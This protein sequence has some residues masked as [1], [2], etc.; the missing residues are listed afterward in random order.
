MK[1]LTTMLCAILLFGG[2][3][4]QNEAKAAITDH[5]NWGQINA[6]QSSIVG[7]ITGLQQ[8]YYVIHGHY[9]QGLQTPVKAVNELDGTEEVQIAYGLKPSD[10]EESWNDFSPNDF[11]QGTKFRI[12]VT[13]DVYSAPEGDGYIVT[14]E[15]NYPAIGPDSYGTE[16]N[17]WIYQHNEGPVSYG[18][19]WDEWFIKLDE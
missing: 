16:G 19:I 15:F 5:P 4:M 17:R 12:H 11:K 3:I 2:V 14:L 6:F 10:Q 13:I 8:A 18:G 9:F 7:M 1:K